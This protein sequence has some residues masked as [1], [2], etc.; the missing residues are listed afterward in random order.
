MV[1]SSANDQLYLG[2]GQDTVIFKVLDN[3][4][5]TAGNGVATWHDFDV[6]DAQVAYADQID[7]SALLQDANVHNIGDFVG[8]EY[9]QASQTVTLSIDR[10][11]QAQGFSQQAILKLTQQSQAITLDELLHNQQILF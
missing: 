5:A 3:S 9:D 2:E 6:A 4:S 7:I 1:N 8:L 11:G 10:D